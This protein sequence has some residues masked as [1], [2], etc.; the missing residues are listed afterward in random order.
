[1]M[2]G[3]CIAEVHLEWC[4]IRCQILQEIKHLISSIIQS[5]MWYIKKAVNLHPAVFPFASEL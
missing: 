1:M 4:A 5:H 2:P 3:S